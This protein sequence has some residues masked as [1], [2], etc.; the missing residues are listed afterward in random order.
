MIPDAYIL[1]ARAKV[2]RALP[3]PLPALL[4]LEVTDEDLD[5]LAAAPVDTEYWRVLNAVVRR[6][7]S[8]PSA[9]R[10]HEEAA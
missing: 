4:L 3:W 8:R 5:R 2:V 9:R 1:E 10:H 7:E 6:I